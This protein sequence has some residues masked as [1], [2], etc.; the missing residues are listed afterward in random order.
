MTS[1]WIP[2]NRCDFC[3]RKLE[4]NSPGGKPDRWIYVA[5]G[6][7]L[8]KACMSWRGLKPG[9]SPCGVSWSRMALY[10]ESRAG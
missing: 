4:P 9:K 2:D 6:D 8:V 1:P 10:E 7:R 3:G 5:R